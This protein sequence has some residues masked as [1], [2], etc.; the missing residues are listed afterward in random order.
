MCVPIPDRTML[1]WLR[2]QLRI[3]EAWR[4]ELLRRS[5]TDA[6]TLERLDR[7]SAWLGGEIDRLE[8]EQSQAA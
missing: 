4:D 3:L 8:Q 6:E 5:E 2:S 7:H 1:G